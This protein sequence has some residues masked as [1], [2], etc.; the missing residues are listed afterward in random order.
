MTSTG[1][2]VRALDLGHRR[3][4]LY[5]SRN[6]AAYWDGRNAHGEPVASGV[7]FC[8][9][10]TAGDFTGMCKMQVTSPPRARCR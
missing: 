10:I 5:Q 8:K 4:G 9:L 3:A 2:V 7:Y 1:R 6:L